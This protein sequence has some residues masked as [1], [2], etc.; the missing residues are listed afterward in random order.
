MFAVRVRRVLFG[1]GALLVAACSDAGKGAPEPQARESSPP[2]DLPSPKV[3]RPP[4][5]EGMDEELR[6]FLQTFV[7]Q[8]EATPDK[9]EAHGELG[10]AYEANYMGVEAAQCYANAAILQPESARWRYRQ[11]IVQRTGGDLENALINMQKAYE[12]APEVP[13]VTIRLGEMLLEAG[14]VEKAREI[15][16]SATEHGEAHPESWLGLANVQLEAGELEAAL[17]SADKA[18]SLDT[19]YQAAHYTRG[20]ILRALGREEEALRELRLGEGAMRRY[21]QDQF[22]VKLRDYGV[23]YGRRMGRIEIMAQSGQA[24]QA[25]V[26]LEKILEKRPDDPMVLGLMART[27]MNLGAPH[28]ALEYLNHSR[29][30]GDPTYQLELDT[31]S[32]FY[33]LQDIARAL[34][35]AAKAVELAPAIGRTHFVLGVCKLSSQDTNGA[36]E[37]LTTAHKCGFMVPELYLQL[38]Q[39]CGMTQRAQEM[40]KYAEMAVGLTSDHV[41]AHLLLVQAHLMLGQVPEARAVLERAKVFAPQDPGVAQAEQAVSQ[42]EGR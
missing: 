29:R 32:A 22:A 36:Y 28:K 9:A 17:A 37:S 27:Q 5:I 4:Q 10:L 20:Q 16:Q 3:V 21:P 33:A 7:E 18:L 6:S 38:A 31:C 19:S 39:V 13:I 11:A 41:Q 30:V 2:T 40:K 42:Q 35:H 26:E 12:T 24:E 8:V 14:R 34:S 23:G 15:C 1:I 25:I